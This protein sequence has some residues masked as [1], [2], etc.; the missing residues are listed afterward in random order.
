MLANQAKKDTAPANLHRR[1]LR[2]RNQKANGLVA[3]SSARLSSERWC[4][5]PT[6]GVLAL[7]KKVYVSG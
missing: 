7:P 6:Y 2:N 3:N 1:N 5:L 4:L